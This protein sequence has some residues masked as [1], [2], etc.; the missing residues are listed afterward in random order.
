MKLDVSNWSIRLVTLFLATDVVLIFLHILY[1]Y[2]GVI[3]NPSFSIEEERGYAEIF[4]YFKEYWLALLLCFLAVRG[5]SLLYLSWSLLFFYLLLD[6]ALQI[7]EKL[8]YAISY[9]LKFSAGFNLRTED[10][11]ELAVSA[12]VG[13]FFLI[14]IATAY[15]FSDR[16]SKEISRYLIMML[17]TLA[18]F[19]IAVDMVHA[20]VRSPSL[21]T[22]LGLVEDGGELVVMSV[23]TCF[24]FSLPERLQL[25]TDK[26][27]GLGRAF[28]SKDSDRAFIDSPKTPR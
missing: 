17:F 20:A 3:S 7:H 13:L 8:G 15:R 1:V 12:L 11:G 18:L 6:D 10:F 22:L 24:V 16:L 27:R 25:R 23:I 28:P 19:G 2:T 4:Q 26:L 9:K 21:H 14:F 5:R